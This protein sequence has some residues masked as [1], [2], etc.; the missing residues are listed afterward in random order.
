M[1]QLLASQRFFTPL[2]TYFLMLE[3]ELSGVHRARHGHGHEHGRAFLVFAFRRLRK[4]KAYKARVKEFTTSNRYSEWGKELPLTN[5]TEKASWQLSILGSC[6]AGICKQLDAS[7]PT[8]LTY[9]S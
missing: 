8:H 7:F 9:F 6:F 2:S 3:G 4:R 5:P 1:L